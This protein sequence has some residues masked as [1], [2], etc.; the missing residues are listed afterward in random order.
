M[1]SLLSLA[2]QAAKNAYAPYSGYRVGCALRDDRGE[3]FT[4]VNVEN[5][6]FGGTICAERHAIGAMVRAGG[7]RIMEMAV[8][9]VDGGSPCGI[10]LQSIAEFCEDPTSLK[11][12]LAD[13][14]AYSLTE[15]LPRSFGSQAIK[16]TE[17]GAE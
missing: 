7:R 5:I 6:S 8:W 1:N 9:T 10:C 14:R 11:I 3:V 17:R 12:T 2:E 15:F 13:G 16:R 4:G